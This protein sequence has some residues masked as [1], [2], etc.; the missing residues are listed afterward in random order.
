MDGPTAGLRVVARQVG[1]AVVID[2]GGEIDSSNAH[3]LRTE[4]EKVLAADPAVAVLDLSEV[5]FLGSAG[6]N[7]LVLLHSDHP[8]ALRIV[9]ATRSVLRPIELT[10]L[11][12]Q[13]PLFTSLDDALAAARPPTGG[14]V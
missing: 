6:L 10:G 3:L 4:V 12:A 2:V 11:D 8:A 1:G 13:L 14:S 9:A 5:E 7:A